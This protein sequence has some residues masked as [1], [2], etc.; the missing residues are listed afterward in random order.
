MFQ[1]V[2]NDHEY[3]RSKERSI[4]VPSNFSASVETF[5]VFNVQIIALEIE[6]EKEGEWSQNKVA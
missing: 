5:T 1:T 4:F 3:S 2:L 6:V